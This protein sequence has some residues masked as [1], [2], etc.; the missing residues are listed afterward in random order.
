MMRSDCGLLVYCTG[1]LYVTYARM[2]THYQLITTLIKRCSF[3]QC[4]YFLSDTAVFRTI[5]ICIFREKYLWNNENI[6]Y[7][8][9]V[10][11]VGWPIMLPAGRSQTRIPMLYWIIQLTS[12]SNRNEYQESSWGNVPGTHWVGDWVD[13]RAGL[14]DLEKR[15]FYPTGTRTPTPRSYSP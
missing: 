5:V 15:I 6:F 4:R 11:V 3:Y 9:R 8:S 10:N 1:Q 12:A 7:T 2:Q 13:L 14:H